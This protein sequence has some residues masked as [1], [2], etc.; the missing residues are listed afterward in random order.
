MRGPLETKELKRTGQVNPDKEAQALEANYA[1]L[2]PRSE[3]SPRPF[4]TFVT[5]Y[6]ILYDVV[7]SLSLIYLMVA[8]S[9]YLSTGRMRKIDHTT[10][11]TQTDRS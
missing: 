5:W 2:F 9:T 11:C 10:M 3:Y 4:V 8:I 1:I 7:I 6:I